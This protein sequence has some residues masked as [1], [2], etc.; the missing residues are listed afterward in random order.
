MQPLRHSP[1]HFSIQRLG[2]STAGVIALTFAALSGAQ[3]AP[4]GTDT[5]KAFK[6]CT[7]ADNASH[8]LEG[9]IDQSQRNDVS[10]IHFKQTPAHAAY[11][12]HND[13]EPQYVITLSGTL[14]F[15]TRGGETFTL[16]PGE[17]LLAE[18]NTGSGHRWKMVDDQPWRRGYVVLKAGASD[19][20]IPND[21]LAT[22]VC[23]APLPFARA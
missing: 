1:R 3:A 16:H 21:P 12:W 6:L 22:K 20:F 11:D 15:E 13:P 5:I 17:V 9:T 7:G 18:D 4:S 23:T 2:L 8:V 14:A 19:S 10:A